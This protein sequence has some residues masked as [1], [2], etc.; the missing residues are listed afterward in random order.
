[1]LDEPNLWTRTQILERLRTTIDR[2]RPVL[3]AGA[4][5]GIVAKAAEAGGADLI[6]VY[7]T[8]RSRI[9]GLPTT[10]IGHSNA[11]TV[12]MFDQIDNVVEHTPI[13]GGAEAAD[14]TFNRMSRLIDSFERTGYHGLINFPSVGMNPARAV[15]RESV[16]QGFGREAEMIAAARARDYFTMAYAWTAEQTRVLASAGADVVIPHAGWTAGGD[17]GRDGG[18]TIESSMDHVQM[19]IEI[20]RSENPECICLAHGGSI[21]EPAD[22]VAL[23]EQTDAQGFVGASSIERIPIERAVRGAVEAFRDQSLRTKKGT[24]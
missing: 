19:L 12:S 15:E 17:S 14:P 3:G 22:T 13:I 24:Q 4:S 21:A 1:V 7:S 11:V 23:Y 9:W 20:A 16:G 10:P 6:I 5:A 18:T 8:G 2:G